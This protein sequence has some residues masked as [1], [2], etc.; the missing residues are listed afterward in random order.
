[1]TGYVIRRV[2]WIIPLLW[3]V[4]TI[5]FFLMQATPG[6][7]FDREKPAPAQVRQN[8]ERKYNLDRP[9]HVQYV[10]YMRALARG[11]LGVS[12]RNNRDVSD[13]IR[14]GLWVSAQLGLMAFVFAIVFG[15]TLGTLS[16]LNQNRLLDYVG[17]LFATAGA[18]LPSFILATLLIMVFSVQ[19]GW[20]DVLG[21][22]FGNYRKMV[23]PVLSLGVLPAAFVARVTRVAVLDVLHQ[24]Y[25]RTAR[26]KGLRERPILLRH[27]LKNALIPVLTIA[28][29]LFATLITGSVIVERIFQINGIGRPFVDAVFIRDYGVIMGTTLLFAAI[30]VMA[31]LV[32]DL[33]Y[34]YVDPRIRY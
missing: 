32:V 4:A 26:A 9:I 5:T 33:L 27:T 7:P 6:G 11:D 3:A 34:A 1:M 2:L 10:S 15:M 29:P 21:W 28:G 12:F 17:V 20:F 23:L 18:A 30:V 24:D 16:A 19:L 14:S 31:N 13:I 25:I 22:E 8:L